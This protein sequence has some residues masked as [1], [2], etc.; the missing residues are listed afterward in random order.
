MELQ[1]WTTSESRPILS[2]RWINVLAEKCQ[3]PDGGE[4][5]PYY[6]L[7]YP[8]WVHVVALTPE[9]RVILTR[10]YRQGVRTFSVELPCGTMHGGETPVEAAARELAEETG[11]VGESG[12][13]IAT[14]WVNAASH[15]NSVHTILIRHVRKTCTPH[16]DPAEMVHAFEVPWTEAVELALRGGI[17][18]AMHV[19]SVLLAQRKVFA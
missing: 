14:N 5:A 13:I 1:P 15:R 16:V 19:A 18:A 6:V 9:G 3:T 17:Q 10:Q 8:D 11:Y 4:V 7:D 12:Q 2:D